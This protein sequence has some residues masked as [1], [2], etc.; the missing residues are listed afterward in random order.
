[1]WKYNKFSLGDRVSHN[2]SPN[3]EFQVH[4][5]LQGVPEEK[6]SYLYSCILVHG[7]PDELGKEYEYHESD[8]FFNRSATREELE[9]LL[10]IFIEDKDY[11]LAGF[12][13]IQMEKL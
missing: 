13:K 7:H 3:L 11:E 4:N 12:L 10:D 6:G 9:E 5:I 1:M 8:I 2:K